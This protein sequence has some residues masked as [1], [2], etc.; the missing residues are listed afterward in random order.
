MDSHC[1]VAAETL[2][3]LLHTSH[4]RAVSTL[5]ADCRTGNR[6]EQTTD[7]DT[8]AGETCLPTEPL[9]FGR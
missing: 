6:G 8:V 2:P 3:T 1:E 4:K 5:S 9:S 7:T